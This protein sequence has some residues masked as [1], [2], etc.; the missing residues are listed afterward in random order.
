MIFSTNLSVLISFLGV[1]WA[2][3]PCQADEVVLAQ[4]KPLV[5]PDNQVQKMTET[6]NLEKGQEKLQLTLT[7]YNGT[8]TAPGF[9]WLRIAS[10]T[11]HFVSEREFAGKKSYSVDVTGELTWG[12][13]QMLVTA[14][15]QKGS[16]FNWKLTTSQPTITSLSPSKVSPGHSVTIVGNNFSG[17]P[18]AN[19]VMFGSH[20][21]RCLSAS[22]DKLIVQ[23]PDYVD[24]AESRVS[25]SVGGMQA[26]TLAL[27]VAA[28]PYLS[29]L[30][31]N[32][33]PP[34]SQFT[35]YGEGFSANQADISV[36][37]GPL[38][39]EIVSVSPT[40]ITVI[41]PVGYGG[42][43]WGFYQP[44]KVQVRGMPARNQLTIS[45][46]QVG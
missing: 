31:A 45:I 24:S 30:S 1:L 29:S 37:V 6:I 11:M 7:Y 17:D 38:Q 41:A 39:C 19:V 2:C 43:P 46:S 26:G 28:Y 40:S 34:G 15:G 27:T 9:T 14:E 4:S 25:V 33:V 20:R 32:W 22:S 44:V 3:P 5:A 35:I 13:N 36:N 42:E 16:T 23:V 8:E 12:G 10:P 18:D 21:A